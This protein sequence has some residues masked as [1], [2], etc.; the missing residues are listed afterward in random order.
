MQKAIV[1]VAIYRMEI[2][3]MDGRRDQLIQSH[4]QYEQIFDADTIDVQGL[5]LH[6]NNMAQV[7]AEKLGIEQPQEEPA[8]Q[9][10][11]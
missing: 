7:N 4:T 1:K 2:D 6:V 10:T 3:R 5:V 8:M 9:E 11:L